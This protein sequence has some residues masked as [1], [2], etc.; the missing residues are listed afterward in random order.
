MENLIYVLGSKGYL[1]SNIESFLKDCGYSVEGISS[2]LTKENIESF[3]FKENTIIINCAGPSANK[4]KQSA[5][6]KNYHHYINL[7]LYELTKSLN[8]KYIHLGTMH[9]YGDHEGIINEDSELNGQSNYVKYRKEHELKMCEEKNNNKAIL[10]RLGNIFGSYNKKMGDYKN[11]AINSFI[12]NIIKGEKI[13]ILSDKETFR[14]YV[15]IEYLLNLI[16]FCI[17]ED[18]PPSPIN[19]VS[20]KSFSALKI[21]QIIIKAKYGKFQSEK[22]FC[23]YRSSCQFRIKNSN[24]LVKNLIGEED[25]YEKIEEYTNK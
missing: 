2:K 7:K 25:I 22:V 12:E 3:G 17:E 5:I 9:I 14:D 11:L 13:E 8:I 15:S 18:K 1:G 20:G 23:N 10:L 19:C 4:C 6:A 16:K 21:A 24:Q